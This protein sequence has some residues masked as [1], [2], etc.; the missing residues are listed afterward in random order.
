MTGT[1]D[2]E[3][4]VFAA[5]SVLVMGY[6][7]AVGIAA[8]LSIV[9]GAGEAADQGIIVRTGEAFQGAAPGR[10]R[11]VGQDRHPHR[12]PPRALVDAALDPGSGSLAPMTSS[13]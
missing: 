13:R 2:V 9:R 6:P 1:V 10:H 4:A 11:R 7:C 5:L 3:R 8:P 12:R